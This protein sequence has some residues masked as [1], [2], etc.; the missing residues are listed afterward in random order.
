MKRKIKPVL[1]FVCLLL[2]VSSCKKD[3]DNS[4]TAV[5]EAD[6]AEAVSQAVYNQGGGM[7]VQ[8]TA[9][10]EYST[11]LMNSRKGA[12]VSDQCGI[13][14]DTIVALSTENY[15]YNFHWNWL[16]T[17]KEMV[18]QT[19]EFNY[20]GKTSYE[21]VRMSSSD[22]AKATI[23]VTG[24]GADSAYYLFNQTYT[25]NGHQ[26][27]KVNQKRSFS[28]LI[29]IVSSDLKISKSTLKILSGTGTVT[30]NGEGSGGKSFS[31][32]GTI[33]FLG[34]EKATLVI[35]NGG[36]YNLIWQ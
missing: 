32:K 19:F 36:T 24:L 25:R 34:N 2:A 14:H 12:K 13:L 18:P 15:G 21:T 9:A 28:S 16:L 30:V 3:D 1:L 23:T 35:T 11:D 20:A 33:S 8:G 22:S 4:T 27:S 31:Y 10:A 5:S 6:V 29:S 7:V 26:N 17:C